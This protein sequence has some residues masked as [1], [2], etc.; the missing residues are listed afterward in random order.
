G[1]VEWTAWTNLS[2]A[3]K[4]VL[5]LGIPASA[6]IAFILCHRYRETAE[7]DRCSD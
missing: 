7:T 1:A 3:Q 6:T 2:T 4:T 5:G